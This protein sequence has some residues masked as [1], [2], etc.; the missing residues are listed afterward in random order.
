MLIQSSFFCKIII[1]YGRNNNN[2]ETIIKIYIIIYIYNHI[3]RAF[4]LIFLYLTFRKRN[5]IKNYPFIN[6]SLFY[7]LFYHYSIIVFLVPNSNFTKERRIYID[8]YGYIFNYICLYMF[9]YEYYF[10]KIIEFLF[11]NKFTIN[12]SN[13]FN[14]LI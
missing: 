4:F 1:W 11:Y 3:Y 12:N 13:C 7:S 2:E 5:I 8:I 9:L 6:Y 10:T 14:I